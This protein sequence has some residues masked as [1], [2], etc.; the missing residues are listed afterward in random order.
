MTQKPDPG[1]LNPTQSPSLAELQMMRAE[2]NAI[3]NEIAGLRK[4]LKDKKTFQISDQVAKGVVIA[5]LFWAAI[6]FVL[7]LLSSRS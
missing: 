6:I 2:L 7:Q 4:D 5:G 3:Y 1:R